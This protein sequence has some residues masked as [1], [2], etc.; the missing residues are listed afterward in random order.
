[1]T[2]SILTKIAINEG[3]VLCSISPCHS[4]SN[5]QL[6]IPRETLLIS[7]FKPFLMNISSTPLSLLLLLV[8]II[9]LP[10]N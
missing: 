9:G 1:M 4:S 7:K 8:I 3:P 5:I 2:Y 6:L 10:H